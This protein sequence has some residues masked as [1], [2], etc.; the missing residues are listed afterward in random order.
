[1]IYYEITTF[2]ITS[3]FGVFEAIFFSEVAIVA[4]NS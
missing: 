3:G 1:M 4:L 2:K